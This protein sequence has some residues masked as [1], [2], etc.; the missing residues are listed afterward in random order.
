M[1]EAGIWLRRWHQEVGAVTGGKTPRGNVAAPRAEQKLAD[2][3][4]SAAMGP[5]QVLS[6]ARRFDVGGGGRWRVTQADRARGS[7]VM[8]GNGLHATVRGVG[9]VDLKFTSG[10]IVQLK[11]VLHVPS[12]KKNLVSGSRLMKDGFK[13]V[14]ES[15]KVVLSKYGTFVGKGYDCEG[16]FRFSLEDFCDNVVNHEW[17]GEAILTSCH[18]LNRVPTKN[19][20][21]TPYEEWEKKRP[22]LSYLRTWGCLALPITKKRKLGPKTVDCVFLGYAAHSIA[23]RFLVVKYGVDDMNVGTIFESRG[24]T[25]FEDIFPMRDMHGMSS[26]ESDPIHETPMESD[27]E[28][29]DESSD[30]DEDN[31]EAPTRSKRQRTAKSFG[32]DFIVYL[33]DDTPTTI[34]EALASPDA[35]YWKEAVQ[36]EMDSILANGTWELTERPYGCKPVGCKWVFK[37]KL[38]A[39]VPFAAL[40]SSLPHP[41]DYVHS[42]PGE[43]ASETPSVEI[44]HRETGDKV[45]GSVS[46]RLLVVRLLLRRFG[47]FID[48]SDYTMGDINNSHGGGAAAGATFPVAMS[49]GYTSYKTV[50]PRVAPSV[51]PGAKPSRRQRA[52]RRGHPLRR[53]RWPAPRWRRTPLPKVAGRFFARDGGCSCWEV[54]GRLIGAGMLGRRL[55]VVVVWGAPSHAAG[56][57]IRRPSVRIWR[58]GRSAACGGFPTAVQ[59]CLLCSARCRFLCGGVKA[60]GPAEV[61]PAGRGGRLRPNVVLVEMLSVEVVRQWWPADVSGGPTAGTDHG[62][63][64][65]RKVQVVDDGGVRLCMPNSVLDDMCSSSASLLRS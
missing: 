18:V 61:R 15:N 44:L 65:K 12:I 8:M 26:W 58:E 64:R 16:M 20:E 53:C 59:S 2:E 29:D 41:G 28:S 7:S 22:T 9:T 25:F 56:R 5:H 3:A 10:K 35:D 49:C 57:R 34:S 11:N 42:R 23:Y 39:D 63:K 33:V 36:S 14:F 37:K 46:A 32:N 30:S 24:A 60:D 19:K 4:L 55:Q 31:N 50:P 51:T 17:W 45:F 27:E 1:D 40:L 13:L 48:R 54:G 52:P 38:R 43:Q 62:W 47:Y 21:I 6:M